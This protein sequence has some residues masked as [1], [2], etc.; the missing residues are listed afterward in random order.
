MEI[1]QQCQSHQLIRYKYI[2]EN[3]KDVVWELNTD[4]VFTFVSP[5]ANDLSGYEAEEI[6]GRKIIDFLADES[7]LYFSDL[8]M[9]YTKQR[10]NGDAG[11]IVLHAVQFVCK[12]GLVK[13]VEISANRMFEEGRLVGYIGTTRDITAKKEYERQLSQY[14][15]EL[16]TLNEKL[17]EMATTDILTGV[18]NRRKFKDDLTSIINEKVN[19]YIQFSLIFF[20]ID[21][22]KYINDFFGHRIGD[23]VLQHVAR[24]VSENIRMADRLFR[25]GGDEF[26]I[27]LSE[28][29]LESAKIVA[30]KIR[31]IIRNE[32]FGIDKDITA[33][34]GVVE[35]ITD[36]NADEI[37]AR[38]D[39]VLYEAKIRGRNIVVS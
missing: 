30:E 28:A 15:Q 3:I 16:K 8:V 19:S 23:L 21:H 29:N 34:L 10:V 32:D 9:Q 38:L 22:F 17:E 24:L 33:S 18:Y 26:I 2:L 4:Y 11:G 5:N 39:K 25:W 35:Y 20:D 31:N 12:N 36:E 27:I 1:D 7:K 6:V 37:I 13:W 14:V